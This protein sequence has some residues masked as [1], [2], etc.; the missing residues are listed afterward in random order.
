MLKQLYMKIP[1]L[2][3]VFLKFHKKGKQKMNK[4][5]GITSGTYLEKKLKDKNNQK[6][7]REEICN[8][9]SFKDVCKYK[10]VSK[11]NNGKIFENN[12]E[13]KY[14]YFTITPKAILATGR[15]TTTGKRT[16]KTF[17]AETEDEAFNM[18]LTCKLEL[19]K[20]GG[21][22]VITKS[23]KSIIDLARGVIE[24]DFKLG[25]I[26]KATLKRKNDTLKKLEQEKF[27]HLPI[28]KVKREDI[29]KYLESLKHYSRKYNK[30]NI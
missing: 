29:V 10:N 30:T 7:K 9:C 4:I 1:F 22:K 14:F 8:K 25:R 19:E 11:F 18:A 27:T 2:A 3:R 6:F 13:C 26:K 15:D 21:I 20:N 5:K 17:I 23:N 24:E 28:A 16:T 12:V